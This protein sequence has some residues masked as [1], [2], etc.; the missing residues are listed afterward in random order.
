M[1]FPTVIFN[2]STGSDT[3]ASGAG[4]GTAIT[5]TDASF[6][7]SVVTVPSA[8]LSGV[9]TDG[10]HVL[11]L[12]T[13]TGRQFFEIT[14]KADSG[15]VTANVTVANAP[16]GTSTGRT[17]AIGGKRATLNNTNSRMIFSNAKAGWTIDIEETGSPYTLTSVITLGVSGNTTD[18]P[19][20]IKSSSTTRPLITTSTNSTRLFNGFGNGRWRWQHLAFSN[21]AGTRDL[22]LTATTADTVGWE[23]YDCTFDGFSVAIDGDFVTF[24]TFI[25][26][27]VVGCEI[28][29]CTSH[30]IHNGGSAVVSGCYIHDN[31]G[32]GFH[33]S[34]VSGNRTS[35]II[36]CVFDSNDYGF[37][38]TSTNSGRVV[39]IANSVFYN[40]TTTG[41]ATANTSGNAAYSITN[42][43]FVSNT[44]A[45]SSAANTGFCPSI[46]A[47][48]FQGNGTDISGF[49]WYSQLAQV[50]ISGNPF[51]NA[52]SGDFSLDGVTGEGD[53]LAETG[54]PLTIN[55]FAT[56]TSIGVF[57]P[58][59]GVA[60]G[61]SG[62]EPS[63]T[64]VG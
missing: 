38:D 35:A 54:V 31:A 59:T 45:I 42:C 44:T 29:N 41:I 5:N 57:Q 40:Q 60:G 22:G 58:G 47:C 15:L 18:G 21:T 28:K 32:S 30:A 43:V 46:V 27:H 24:F 3:A 34:G 12:L 53:E 39:T 25:G 16:A 50:S 10:S 14:A 8:D 13:S 48:A 17:Y 9:A 56:G 20:T 62:A 37:R 2:N 19:V 61:G 26:L 49:T 51:T 63:Y 52:A 55:G 64:F 1:A 7:G 36:G 33:T 6:S 11:W 23:I 4:P